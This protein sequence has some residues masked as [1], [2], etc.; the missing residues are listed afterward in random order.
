MATKVGANLFEMVDGPESIIARQFYERLK[1]APLIGEAATYDDGIDDRL[2]G[3]RPWL[4]V[5]AQTR[6]AIENM[7]TW[8]AV[9][10]PELPDPR[11]KPS[12][13]S[14]VFVL[15]LTTFYLPPENRGDGPC[16]L[17]ATNLWN[18]V[19]KLAY[20]LVLFHP[21][22]PSVSINFAT[23]EVRPLPLLVRPDG[24]RLVSIRTKFETDIDPTTGLFL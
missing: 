17:S 12:K 2:Q 21:A 6:D 23:T 5:E 16:P 20:S 3:F 8:T 11:D 10:E 18:E 14:T 19:R 9:V 15:V 13:R 24:V 22:A 1:A 7:D 4:L